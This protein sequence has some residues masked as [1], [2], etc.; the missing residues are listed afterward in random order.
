MTCFLV[1]KT[2]LLTEINQ[3]T[4]HNSSNYSGYSYF[5]RVEL[6]NGCLSLGHS[7]TFIHSTLS[8]PQDTGQIDEDRL[9]QN[10]S[11]AIMAYI[12]V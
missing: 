1:T 10:L 9:R 3:H 8:G 6:Q 2:T 12:I 7:N 11:L 5:N 4:L